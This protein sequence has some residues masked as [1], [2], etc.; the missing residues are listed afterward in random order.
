[1]QN[2]EN[3]YAAAAISDIMRPRDTH[4]FRIITQI[5]NSTLITQTRTTILCPSTQN[6]VIL[7][8]LSS[9]TLRNY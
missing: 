3:I 4:V 8:L 6:S 7:N 2:T 1:M 5:K 9:V